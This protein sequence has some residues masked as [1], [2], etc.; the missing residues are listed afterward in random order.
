MENIWFCMV[1][2]KLKIN[3]IFK[4]SSAIYIAVKAAIVLARSK[5]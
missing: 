4:T 5:Y 2:E 1:N 3:V